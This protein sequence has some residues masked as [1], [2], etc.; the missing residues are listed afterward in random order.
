MAL[1]FIWPKSTSTSN[2]H[3]ESVFES[4]DEFLSRMR[5]DTHFKP[6]FNAFTRSN[7]Q[8][9]TTLSMEPR[10]FP[11]LFFSSQ[12]RTIFLT[13]SFAF[14]HCTMYSDFDY[15]DVYAHGN[16]GAASHRAEHI[17][18]PGNYELDDFKYLIVYV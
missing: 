4:F 7:H 5:K 8:Y 17:K 13:I 2:P 3:I 1:V 18:I 9:H 6:I 15:L 16:A 12:K 14:I 10:L 11:F